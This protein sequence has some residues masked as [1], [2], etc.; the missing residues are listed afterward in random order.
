MDKLNEI[1]LAAVIGMAV[2]TLIYYVYLLSVRTPDFFKTMMTAFYELRI[3]EEE[4]EDQSLRLST[5]RLSTT[6]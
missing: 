3:F 1:I 4:E 6:P 2:V 5:A